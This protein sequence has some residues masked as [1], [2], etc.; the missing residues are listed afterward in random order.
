MTATNSPKD[1]TTAATAELRD[2][3]TSFERL[4][5]T[6]DLR[7]K[8]CALIPLA[9]AVREMGKALI[10]R[11]LA[12]GARDRILYYFRQYPQTIIPGAELMVVSGIGEWARRVR[13]LRVQFGWKIISGQA[14]KDMLAAKQIVTLGT[15]D[16]TR[17]TAKDYILVDPMQDLEAAYRW[18]SAH[19]IRNQGGSTKKRLLAYLRANVGKPVTGE[20]LL[21]VANKKREWT[22]RAREL[23]TQD[24]WPVVTRSTGR[25]DLAVGEYLLEA[26]RQ[27]PPHDR[28]I[29]DDVQLAVYERDK[30]ICT[31]CGW[32]RTRWTREQP[33]FLEL[34]HIKPHVEGGEN[35]AENLVVLC[36]VCHDRVH[37]H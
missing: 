32:N 18:N 10:P 24:G 37:A 22:R 4:A 6:N 9:E 34:H 29:D 25:P 11:S 19:D 7:A 16:L 17:M 28:D 12:S 21:Y 2:F 35:Q 3:L 33:R 31:N 27:M 26:D 15:E 8:V 13:E 5:E 14:V 36:N 23:R 20:E 1:R 30:Y